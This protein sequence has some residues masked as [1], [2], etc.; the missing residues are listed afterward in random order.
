ML[1][2]LLEGM[3]QVKLKK[4]FHAC[5]LNELGL[6]ILGSIMEKLTLPVLIK[7]KFHVFRRKVLLLGARYKNGIET[8][9][10]TLIF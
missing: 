9:P 5:F 10:Q 7:F 4:L 6:G 1:R 3:A 8:L 2:F